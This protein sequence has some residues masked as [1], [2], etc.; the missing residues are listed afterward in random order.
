MRSLIW[1]KWIEEGLCPK[2]GEKGPFVAGGP[3]CSTHGPYE[4]QVIRSDTPSMED[5]LGEE[6]G[7]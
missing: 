1:R 3:V 2:C 6:D 5:W 4:F 7:K